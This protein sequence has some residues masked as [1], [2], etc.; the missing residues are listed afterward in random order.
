MALYSANIYTDIYQE[1]IRQKKDGK[2]EAERSEKRGRMIERAR[3]R[4]ETDRRYIDFI[5]D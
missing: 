5:Y 1:E 3:D 2:T 4:R